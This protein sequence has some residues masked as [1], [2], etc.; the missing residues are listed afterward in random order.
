MI[1]H[2]VPRLLIVLL[3]GALTACSAAPPAAQEP[4]DVQIEANEFAFKA[5][6]TT[7]STGVPY[8][9]TV[10][11]TGAIPHE[12]MI[13]PPVASGMMGMED[14]DEMAL[15]MIP[16]DDLPERATK[17]FEYTF[18]EPAPEG[19]LEFA[20]HVIGHYEAGMKLPIVVK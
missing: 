6:M 16:D 1:S 3:I 7:F 19:K 20:C 2:H 15:A 12:I 4:V 13:V 11:N 8:R 14:L 5:S 17:T 9:F 18:T 10:T